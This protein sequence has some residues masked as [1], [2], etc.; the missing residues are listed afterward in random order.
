MPTYRGM[1][2]D[3]TPFYVRFTNRGRSAVCFHCRSNCRVEEG[4]FLVH[5]DL[6]RDRYGQSQRRSPLIQRGEQVVCPGSGHPPVPLAYK[7]P[8][9]V[10][11]PQNWY[12]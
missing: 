5:Y 11:L 4:A 3:T 6:D 10:P 8:D 1:P 9:G 2:T 12:W 7:F